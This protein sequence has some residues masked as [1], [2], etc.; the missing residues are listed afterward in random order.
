M[1]LALTTVY[2]NDAPGQDRLSIM[3]TLETLYPSTYRPSRNAEHPESEFWL[4]LKQTAML[5]KA[6]LGLEVSAIDVGG[7]DM[8][9]A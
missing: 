5:I 9:F 6:R 8:H 4:A 7:W 1:G 2:A 3:D